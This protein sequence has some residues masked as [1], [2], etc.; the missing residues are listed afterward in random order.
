MKSFDSCLGSMA[1][2]SV[3]KMS[4]I[5]EYYGKF[6]SKSITRGENRL[7]SGHLVSFSYDPKTNQALAKVLASKRAV[8][9]K[10]EVSVASLLANNKHVW[11][12][13]SISTCDILGYH[14]FID[15]HFIFLV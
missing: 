14:S 13:I 9:Y 15:S 5:E 7:E 10:V 4:A 12:F 11:I 6:F 3:I 2:K 8:A 1:T